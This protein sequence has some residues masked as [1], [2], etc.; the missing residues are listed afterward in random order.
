MKRDDG[1]AIGLKKQ[2][3]AMTDDKKAKAVLL[4]QNRLP[5]VATPVHLV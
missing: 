5:L 4:A 3:E 2:T 1:Q